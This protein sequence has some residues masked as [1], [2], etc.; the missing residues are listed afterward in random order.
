MQYRVKHD[1]RSDRGGFS[2]G[3]TVDLDETEAGWFNFDSPGLLEPTDKPAEPEPVEVTEPEPAVVVE[4][5]P[6]VE[7]EKPKRARRT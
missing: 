1:Y 5:E 6:A 7:V 4:G 2:K 3:D